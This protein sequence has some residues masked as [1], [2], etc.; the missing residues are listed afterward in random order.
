MLVSVGVEAEVVL[1]SLDVGAAAWVV[2]LATEAPVSDLGADEVLT[3]GTEVVPVALVSSTLTHTPDGVVVVEVLALTLV[4][5]TGETFVPCINWVVEVPPSTTPGAGVVFVVDTR[6]AG[7]GLFVVTIP[8]VRPGVAL[9]TALVLAAIWAAVVA[10]LEFV[11]RL[12]KLPTPPANAET[13]MVTSLVVT[14]ETPVVV[15]ILMGVLP[16]P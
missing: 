2:V 1:D 13:G 3:G 7:A 15:V 16:T 10:R 5:G 14:P 6:V 9:E 12:D 8:V 4:E 11:I